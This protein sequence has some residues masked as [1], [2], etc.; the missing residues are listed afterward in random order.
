[1]NVCPVVEGTFSF[2]QFGCLRGGWFLTAPS[3][4]RRCASAEFQR[5]GSWNRKLS[6]V[7]HGR[8]SCISPLPHREENNLQI[9]YCFQLAD[10]TSGTV[11]CSTRSSNRVA[12]VVRR[13]PPTKCDLYHNSVCYE[14][15]YSSPNAQ[16]RACA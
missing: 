14:L 15:K 8:N 4:S 11:A 5:N 6:R 16:S 2:L 3:S 9:K 12:C 7:G 1:M 10:W 13:K